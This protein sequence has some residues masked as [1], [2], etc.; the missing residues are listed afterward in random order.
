LGKKA[1]NAFTCGKKHDMQ[2]W[3]RAMDCDCENG[4][5]RDRKSAI[6]IT[7]RF[8]SQNASVD[9]L[10]SFR[11][12]ICDRQRLAVASHSQEAHCES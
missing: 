2:I 5:D 4:L 1:L 12:R 7:L 11:K 6:T 8:L 10:L 3:D 9:G